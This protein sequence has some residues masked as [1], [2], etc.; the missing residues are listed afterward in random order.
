M[1]LSR[2]RNA[3]ADPRPATGYVAPPRAEGELPSL[4]VITMARDEGTMIRR[5]VDYYA[6][7]VGAEHLVVIDDNSADGST[8]D[9]PCPVIRI[10][11]LRKQSFEPS[12]M[13]LLAGISAGLLEAYDAVMFCDA[14]E[15]VVAEPRA[16]ESLRHFVA[17]RPGREAVGVLGLNVVHDVTREDALRDDEP[18]LGQR[19]LAKFLPLMCKPSMKWQPAAWAHASHGIECPYE[20][21]RELFMFHMK[22]ADRDH[23]AEVAAHRHHLNT[24]EGRAKRTSWAQSADEMVALLDEIT[25]DLDRDAIAPFEVKGLGLKRIVKHRGDMWRATGEGQVVAMRNRPMVRVP[26]RFLGLL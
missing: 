7:Q 4:A 14:D 26:D 22:F 20:I 2:R 15:F 17:A 1:R 21:D 3:E 10:P 6:G 12:R 8:D 9:L 18:I 24:T 5:W 16:H 25:A 13:A 23:L 19:R 11:Y